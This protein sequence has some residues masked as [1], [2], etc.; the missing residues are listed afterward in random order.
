MIGIEKTHFQWKE[1]RYNLKKEFDILRAGLIKLLVVIILSSTVFLIFLN[2]KYDID[3]LQPLAALIAIVL[4]IAVIY[5]IHARFPKYIVMKDTYLYRGLDNDTA[6]KWKYAEITRC[7][8]S[9]KVTEGKTYDIM[10][11]E[12]SNGEQA[13]LFIAPEISVSELKSFLLS[14]GISL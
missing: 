7:R 13:R 12:L 5:F 3:I 14:K 6:E 11:I 4:F 9:F 2:I 8:F 1:P 10:E